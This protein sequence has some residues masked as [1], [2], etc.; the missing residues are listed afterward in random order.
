[1]LIIGETYKTAR[2]KK[3]TWFR[4]SLS[5]FLIY[6]SVYGGTV[7][8]FTENMIMRSTKEFFLVLLIVYAFW[9]FLLTK[10]K[11]QSIV[12]T[13]L[14]FIL[15]FITIIG[16]L[17]VLESGDWVSY[18]YGIKITI[19]PMSA[20]FIGFL[21]KKYDVK[22][23]KTLLFIYVL[24]ILGW[25]VQY[26]LGL[27]RLLAMGFEYG[28]NVKHFNSNILRLPSLVGAPDAY[29]F[30]LCILGIS[31]ET[32]DSFSNRK[33]TKWLIKG[34]TL[35]FLLLAT[36]RSAILL[37]TICQ[38]FLFFR[39]VRILPAK[40]QLLLLS[41][42]SFVV[43]I[44]PIALLF[45]LSKSTLASSS[46][47]KERLSHWSDYLQSVFTSEGLIG[48]GLGTVG[49][50]SRRISELGYQSY[51]Y[52]VDNQYIAFYEQIGMIGCLLLILLAMIIVKNI[53]IN[54]QVYLKFSLV[55][56]PL[57]VGTLI[58]CY[59]TNVLEIYP[60]NVIFWVMIGYG[61]GNYP[62]IHDDVKGEYK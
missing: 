59:F 32:S 60:F 9:D 6:A 51:D 52:A 18:A 62:I 5:F 22:I 53:L 15:L 49:A 42:G 35:L 28:V 36:I 26:N 55:I 31:L 24:I 14:F 50:A 56:L 47:F 33:M 58:S 40:K 11:Q 45:F 8:L 30:L 44:V 17:G 10:D 21:L 41:F 57:F 13:L 3:L 16:S 46:S 48:Y 34:T 39:S 12:K 27:D 7:S 25:V 38:A 61:M 19:L 23:D 4:L 54:N 20:I 43:A 1:M 2:Y 29:A 37:W